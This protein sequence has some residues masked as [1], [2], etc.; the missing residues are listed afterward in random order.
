MRW[1]FHLI[2]HNRIDDFLSGGP[3]SACRPSRCLVWRRGHRGRPTAAG[4]VQ[5]LGGPASWLLQQTV[6]T[7]L[8]T[9]FLQYRCP[10]ANSPSVRFPR[11][12]PCRRAGYLRGTKT[13]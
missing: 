2:G 5:V 11:V 3:G 12:R 1:T 6:R 9:A 7:V 10:P 13:R 4:P 8:N